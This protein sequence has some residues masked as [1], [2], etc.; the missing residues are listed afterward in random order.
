MPVYTRSFIF[1]QNSLP[2]MLEFS[3]TL[4]PLSCICRGPFEALW[5]PQ[6]ANNS[7]TILEIHRLHFCYKWAF[8][9]LTQPLTVTCGGLPS[10]QDLCSMYSAFLLRMW[11]NR[12]AVTPATSSRSHPL[13]LPSRDHGKAALLGQSEAGDKATSLELLL[14]LEIIGWNV[15]ELWGSH[16]WAD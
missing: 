12:Y 16:Q 8:L 10:G 2:S 1:P 14:V 4:S 5:S 15:V 11:R 9:C 3:H 13:L 6:C 7:I